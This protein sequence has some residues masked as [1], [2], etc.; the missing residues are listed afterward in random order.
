MT[1]DILSPVL[2]DLLDSVP[3][4]GPV[5]TGTARYAEGDSELEG[6]FAHPVGADGP[7]PGVLVLH[8]WFGMSDHVRVRAQMLARLGYVALAGDVY[9]ADVEVT[10]GGEAQAQAGRFY[11]DP[12]LFR[13][14]VKA[15]LEA[16]RADPAVDSSRIAVMGYCFG[17]SG[18]LELA[19]TGEEAAGFVSFHGNLTS[20][21][22]AE[23][24]SIASP[25][26]VL[27]GA[28]DPVVPPEAVV[29]FEDE[30]RAGGADDWQIVSYSGALHAFAVPGTN[31]PEHGAA[32]DATAN[33][34][35]WRAM[36]DFFDEVFA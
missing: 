9:G 35:S 26:L 25:I 16:L 32:F 15:N 10:D 19:R 1:D 24:D 30:M 34:R 17:G 2:Q 11:G 21:A 23:A 5:S 29:A 4:S 31:S 22:P 7:R 3:E 6:Y 33:R 20:G 8:D 12:A 27:T 36:R 18:A 13:A 14:R 28:D